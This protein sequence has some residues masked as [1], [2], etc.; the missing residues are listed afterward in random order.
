[1]AMYK[2]HKNASWQDLKGKKRL[3][4][5]K[6][7]WYICI[8]LFSLQDVFMSMI[9]SNT[10]FDSWCT[11]SLKCHV[12]IQILESVLFFI[13]WNHLSGLSERPPLSSDPRFHQEN[14]PEKEKKNLLA[15]EKNGRNLRKRQSLHISTPSEFIILDLM[16]VLHLSW[17]TRRHQH[18][19]WPSSPLLCLRCR[20]FPHSLHFDGHLWWRAAL[21]H[22]AGAGA[23]PQ[24]RS[25]IH[26]EAHLPHFQ[27]WGP[28]RCLD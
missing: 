3:K 13:S 15:A 11:F 4:V 17:H 26:M 14:L 12:L 8:F 27:R 16:I 1:M 10:N 5:D 18:A 19:S 9:W 21:L 23:V 6:K 7:S 24:N 2:R 22:G 25:H 20:C 28:R